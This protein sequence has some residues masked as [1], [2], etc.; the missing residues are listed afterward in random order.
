MAARY[1]LVLDDESTTQRELAQYLSFA[2]DFGLTASDKATEAALV[3]LL[4]TD[5]NGNYGA[6]SINYDVRFTEEGLRSLFGTAFTSSDEVF[7]R[8][9]MRLIV[10]ANYI[11]KGNFLAD[12]D[13]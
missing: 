11:G 4:P 10:L 2:D 13:W 3:P 7:L 12:R 8:R 9:I 5:A 6:V 1:N